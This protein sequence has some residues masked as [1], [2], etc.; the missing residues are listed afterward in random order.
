M[1]EI[2]AMTSEYQLDWERSV[3][4]NRYLL[5]ERLPQHFS[6]E[7][8][9]DKHR[10]QLSLANSLWQMGQKGMEDLIFIHNTSE[11]LKKQKANEALIAEAEKILLNLKALGGSSTGVVT[12]RIRAKQMLSEMGA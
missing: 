10:A 1:V 12:T 5:D 3:I 9:Q 6:S 11:R 7:D 8:G 2:A 4:Y